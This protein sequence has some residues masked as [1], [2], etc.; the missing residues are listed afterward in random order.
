MQ[1]P[2]QQ[3]SAPR[4]RGSRSQPR[5]R[6]V[7]RWLA[8]ATA[9]AVP[10]TLLGTA[11]TQADPVVSPPVVL[12]GEPILPPGTLVQLAPGA[13]DVR[14][15]ESAFGG[16]VAVTWSVRNDAGR[17]EVWARVKDERVWGAKVRV[18]DPAASA[19]RSTMDLDSDGSL[20]VG[21]AERRGS[22]RSLVA[23]RV[24]GGSAGPRTVFPVATDDGPYVAAG[25]LHDVVAWT[26]PSG[27]VVRPFAAVDAGAGFATPTVISSP[28]WRYDVLPGTLTVNADAPQAHALYLSKD[29]DV[30]WAQT[31]W[32][33]LDSTRG[34]DWAPTDDTGP[35]QKLDAAARRPHVATD[36][37]G[38][39]VLVV[40]DT[41]ELSPDNV[42]YPIAQ[43]FDP[44]LPGGIRQRLNEPRSVELPQDEGVRE[45]RGLH[46]RQ[47]LVMAAYTG[48]AF[49][50]R[51]THPAEE[52]DLS[53][54][55]T[56]GDAL[57]QPFEHWFYANVEEPEILCLDTESVPTGA[58]ILL[59]SVGLSLSTIRPGSGGAPV[60]ASVPDPLL[61]IVL[62]TE[63]V[64]GTQDPT[65]LLDHTEG[66][67]DRPAPLLRFTKLKN[68]KITGKPVV[69]KKLK[70]VAGQWRPAP[71]EVAHRWFVNGTIVKGATKPTFALKKKHRG[72]RVS[73]R[74]YLSR[75]GFADA[76]VEVK[77]AQKVK[78]KPKKKKKKKGRKK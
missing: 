13:T 74:L 6:R 46:H 78:P 21:W 59:G 38:L 30:G 70:A 69:G 28:A 76:V 24:T 54:A 35:R 66:G 16:A 29:S 64:A 31:S 34:S 61:P 60:R 45:V 11:P 18:S 55:D 27:G 67:S 19:S 52:R 51:L 56:A 32:S 3:A 65:W 62:L 40:H 2:R 15:A 68:P 73:V 48:P 37:R 36:A 43:V 50:K 7:A 77:R 63:D 26:A 58:D 33:V 44:D 9:L 49:L 4:V 17:D 47:G 14:V 5:R 41:D 20:L 53:M 10:L 72:K 8:T 42:V 12:D 57:C 71:A 25:A 39:A 22:S 75:A 1:H 23:R